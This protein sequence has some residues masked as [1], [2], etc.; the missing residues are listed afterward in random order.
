MLYLKVNILIADH[1]HIIDFVENPVEN[2]SEDIPGQYK[3]YQEGCPKEE[4]EKYPIMM[5]EI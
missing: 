3:Y 5:G 2:V 4:N 1:Q